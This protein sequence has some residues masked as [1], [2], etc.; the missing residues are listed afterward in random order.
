MEGET[1][2]KQVGNASTTR[3]IY[4]SGYKWREKTKSTKGLRLTYE[5][6]TK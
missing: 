1:L 5:W 3:D 4:I 6:F 2:K